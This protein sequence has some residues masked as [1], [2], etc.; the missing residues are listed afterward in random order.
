MAEI[1]AQMGLEVETFDVDLDA[2]R[3]LRAFHRLSTRITLTGRMWLAVMC[4]NMA[5]PA[6]R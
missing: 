6:A 3:H 5:P 4:P 1:F 2:V